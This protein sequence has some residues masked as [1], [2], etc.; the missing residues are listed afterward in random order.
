[1]ISLE[2]LGSRIFYVVGLA[3]SGVATLK[4]LKTSKVPCYA[5]DDD[6]HNREQVSSSLE[7]SLKPPDEILWAEIEALVLSP[8]V[9]HTYPR[10]HRAA[11]LAKQ[12]NIPIIC[13]IDLLAQACPQAHY[14]GVTG[15]NGKSTTTA[16]IHHL[17][18][19]AGK[20]VQVGGNIGQ[21]VLELEPLRTKEEVYALELSSYQLERI[22]HL[23]LDRAVWL[24]ISPDHLD[25][26]GSLEGYIEA[27]KHI[28]SPLGH[29]QHCV[30]GI[31]D[32][33]S[34]SLFETLRQ[35]PAKKV[36]PI[37]TKEFLSEGICVQKGALLKGGR[38]LAEMS[39]ITSLRG[40][41]NAQN[42][43]AAFAVLEGLEL[44]ELLL[45][46]LKTFQGLA[47][48]QELCG[49][50]D[51][52]IFINDSKA[53]NIE[54]TLRALGNYQN[55]YLI[56]GGLPKE[57]GIQGIESY[58]SHLKRIYLIG[59][60]SQAFKVYLKEVGIEGILCDTL[61]QATHC[62]YNDAA[63]DD[64]RDQESVILLSPACAS[65]DQYKNFEERGDHF[66]K[67]VSQILE[68]TKRNN[69]EI[70]F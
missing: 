54:S 64:V 25:R 40:D 24:N 42:I 8:G 12:H 3:R 65:F 13:D 18:H 43:A 39:Q 30:I 9:P 31:D 52:L 37:S 17:L 41:H 47:H 70:Y 21:A 59:T 57:N 33:W 63:R 34:R 19:Y 28:F 46:G 44:E 51:S 36:I 29:P 15:T 35:D 26:H 60:A 32:P 20:K 23:H 7:V 55:V 10:P 49:Q 16:L 58:K 62:A 67:L 22:P 38:P 61:E 50:K 14:I 1:M 27:K 56:L 48:R 11:L 4:I 2:S 68:D 53:T 69:K 5:W 6:P 66:K 45:K